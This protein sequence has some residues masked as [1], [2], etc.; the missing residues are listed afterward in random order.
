VLP[1]GDG[2]RR[3]GEEGD[4]AF[5]S[6]LHLP[7]PQGRALDSA[8]GRR[9]IQAFSGLRGSAKQKAKRRDVKAPFP[10]DSSLSLSLSLATLYSRLRSGEKGQ[11]SERLFLVRWHS[12]RRSRRLSTRDVGVCNQSQLEVLARTTRALQNSVP[13]RAHTR[14]RESPHT[15]TPPQCCVLLAV[16]M[17]AKKW[18]RE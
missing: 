2:P 1:A 13:A 6:S 18:T 14:E 15:Y 17:K 11:A 16:E 8:G 9:S 3:R 4:V 10:L 7:G 12:Q 5:S